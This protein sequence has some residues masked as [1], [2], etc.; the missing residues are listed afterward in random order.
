[1]HVDAAGHITE[2]RQNSHGGGDHKDP[3]CVLHHAEGS[4]R[5]LHVG[6]M[7]HVLNDGEGI[8]GLKVED[9]QILGELIEKDRHD[10][11]GKP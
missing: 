1:M 3:T 2:D 7:K 9:R 8:D 10:N 6:E 4:T 11:D 5:I